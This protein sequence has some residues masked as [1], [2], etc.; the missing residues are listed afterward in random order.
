MAIKHTHRIQFIS[1]SFVWTTN[2]DYDD[3][4]LE[5]LGQF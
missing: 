5:H 2:L 4:E 1:C 3:K